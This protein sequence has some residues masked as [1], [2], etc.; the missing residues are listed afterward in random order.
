MM[1]I[2]LLYCHNFK[3][4]PECTPYPLE[5]CFQRVCRAPFPHDVL[6]P[7]LCFAHNV[8]RC[9]EQR[10]SQLKRAGNDSPCRIYIVVCNVIFVAVRFTNMQY[11]LPTHAMSF[12]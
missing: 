5:S 6:L 2:E 7:N 9:Q 8:L 10:S 12:L 1:F 11:S 3:T 4:L